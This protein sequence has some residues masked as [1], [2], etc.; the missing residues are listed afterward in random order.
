[1]ALSL[2]EFSFETFE[3]RAGEIFTFEDPS[4]AGTVQLELLEVVKWPPN[5]IP[6]GRAVPFSLIFRLAGGATLSPGLP[7]IIHPDLEACELFV[8]RIQPPPG[9]PADAVYYEA[10]F[11]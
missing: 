9:W 1:M 10:A 3:H 11:N 8:P 7:R 4:G 2:A 6:G 5:G